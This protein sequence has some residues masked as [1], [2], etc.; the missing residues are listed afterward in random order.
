MNL[1]LSIENLKLIAN[2][3]ITGSKSESNRLLI[4]QAL[5]P[6]IEI[7][8]LSDSDD[9]KVLQKALLSV[10]KTIDVGHAG[11]A[12]RFLTAYFAANE[13]K[14]VVL[15]GSKRMQ[16]RPIKILV[17]AL[18]ELGA[19]ISYE[20]QEG[21]P[22]LRIKGKQLTKSKVS[23]RADVSSQYISALMLIAPSMPEGLEIDLEK[24]AV[25]VPYLEMTRS[26][27]QKMGV[28]CEFEG[29]KLWVAPISNISEKTI[30]VESD[31]S[32]ASYFYS[33]AALSDSAEIRLT[34]FYENS[35]QGDS[36]LA[37]IYKPFGVETIFSEG[38]IVLKKINERSPK[39]IQLNL[40]ATPDLAQ[41]I[42]VTCLGMKV[43]CEFSGLQTLKIKETDRLVALKTEL[44][45]F[46]AT[47]K[48]S[49]NTLE[50]IPPEKLPSF[51]EIET[52]DDH[53]MAMAF[54]PF[55]LKIPIHI[56]NAE[57]VSKSYPKF[58]RDMETLGFRG[59]KNV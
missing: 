44:E 23:M 32:S 34:K 45:K 47:M 16:E 13:G 38:E 57:V 53:R 29:N 35:R 49:E 10:E 59:K 25:S 56:K 52:Y 17:D 6:Q 2:I 8:N 40:S 43:S 3:H 1:H 31:W 39:S 4:L 51:V 20:N 54:A 24:K 28:T 30:F 19:D 9:T 55:A 41:T 33:L 50:M 12:M 21:F 22:P 14:Q 7:E 27:L 48:I 18:R 42:A 37:K 36:A 46:G 26:L 58:W 11:T 5:F 15:T